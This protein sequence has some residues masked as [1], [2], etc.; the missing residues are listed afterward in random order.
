MI[1][2]RNSL[3]LIV[4]LPL[5]SFSSFFVK[6]GLNFRTINIYFILLRLFFIEFFHEISWGFSADLFL[7]IETIIIENNITRVSNK[8]VNLEERIKK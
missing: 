8:Q 7:L 6:I 5:I 1:K 3:I 4:Y 2:K